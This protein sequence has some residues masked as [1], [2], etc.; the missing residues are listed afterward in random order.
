MLSVLRINLKNKWT[1]TRR[2]GNE[3]NVHYLTEVLKIFKIS[4]PSLLPPKGESTV[5]RILLS[6]YYLRRGETLFSLFLVSSH[7]A[8]VSDGEKI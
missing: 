8:I 1:K 7:G 2:L 4:T 6:A 3:V 5:Q